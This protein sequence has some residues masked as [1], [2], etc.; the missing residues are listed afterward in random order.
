LIRFRNFKPSAK[1]SALEVFML[2]NRTHWHM[3]TDVIVIGYGSAGAVAAMTAH[4]SGLQVVVLEKQAQPNHLTTS[5]MA[6]GVI[7]CPNDIEGAFRYMEALYKV[8]RTLIFSGFGHTTVLKTRHGCRTSAQ[9][10]RY[11]ATAASIR[12]RG[13]RLLTFTRCAAEG[14]V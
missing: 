8:R 10:C 11:T 2:V 1:G 5:F 6:G 13:R 4:D 9:Q 3:E 12:F 14:P 7:I